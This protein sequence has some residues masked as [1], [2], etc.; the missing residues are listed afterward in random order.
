MKLVVETACWINLDHHQ[1]V[2]WMETAKRKDALEQGTAP[3]RR[4]L[5]SRAWLK[6]DKTWQLRTLLLRK[7][8]TTLPPDLQTA[9]KTSLI[10]YGSRD[11][12][13][14]Y[15]WC[16]W[17]VNWTECVFLRQQPK[18]SWNML[19]VMTV[20]NNNNKSIFCG[21]NTNTGI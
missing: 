17:F 10:S 18:N 1:R 6:T 19:F 20:C 8:L 13:G 21:R 2:V 14:F 12:Y 15:L 5:R 4:W 7:H 11:C 3:T 9:L 16:L